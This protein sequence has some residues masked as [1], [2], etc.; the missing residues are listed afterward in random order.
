ML[1]ADGGFADFTDVTFERLQSVGDELPE[2]PADYPQL[3]IGDQGIKRKRW[4][5]EGYERFDER[6]RLVRC[7][8]KGIEVRT[9]IH[10]TV[11]GAADALGVDLA[12]LDE[13]VARAGL[14]TTAVAFNPLRSHYR[15]EPPLNAWE[16]EHRTGSPEERTAHLHMTTY[17]PDLNL[18]APGMGAAELVDVGRKLT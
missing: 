14:G 1:H 5:V 2:D 11:A 8:P 16:R 13:A 3:R 15:V 6:G 10:D 12:R 18:S 9:R 7:D 17:G 4:Y